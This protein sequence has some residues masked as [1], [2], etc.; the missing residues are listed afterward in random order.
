MDSN[1]AKA[2]GLCR[3]WGHSRPGGTS[4]ASPENAYEWLAIIKLCA[5][6]RSHDAAMFPSFGEFLKQLAARSP[7]IMIGYLQKDEEALSNFLPGILAGL[8][9]SSRPEAA[10]SLMESWID[11]GRHY[12]ARRS[13]L[14]CGQPCL[15]GG[16]SE[17]DYRS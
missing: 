14:R 11:Q 12:M 4:S 15:R 8:A 16:F 3:C 2:V 6:V 9:E 10:Q 1:T 13:P 7:D 5:A 17:M